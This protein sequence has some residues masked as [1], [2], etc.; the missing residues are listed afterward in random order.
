MS[1][2]AAIVTAKGSSHKRAM[3]S[4]GLSEQVWT[5]AMDG[6]IYTYCDDGAGNLTDMKSLS[7][8]SMRSGV[9]ALVQRGACVYSGAENGAVACWDV[10]SGAF[11]CSESV[12]SN[13]VSTMTTVGDLARPT[14]S[15]L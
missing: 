10:G 5:G 7:H 15:C 1:K 4:E 9:R 2:S 13:I 6:R 14:P 12:H 3:N 11:K 8:E